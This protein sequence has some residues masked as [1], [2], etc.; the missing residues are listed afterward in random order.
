MIRIKRLGRVGFKVSD[1]QVAQP[2]SS[3]RVFSW[4][5]C[6]AD[7]HTLAFVKGDRAWLDHCAYELREWNDFKIWG[8]ALARHGSPLDWGPKPTTVNLWGPAPGWR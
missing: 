4:L 5:R 3:E 7:H 6:N 8:D 2:G 1:W